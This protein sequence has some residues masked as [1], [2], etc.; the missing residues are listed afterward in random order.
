MA[1]FQNKECRQVEVFVFIEFFAQWITASQFIFHEEKVV[2]QSEK[3]RASKQEIIQP[4]GNR[5]IDDYQ[6]QS[7]NDALKAI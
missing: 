4:V 5:I 2:C 1:M 7:N 6:N 3:K